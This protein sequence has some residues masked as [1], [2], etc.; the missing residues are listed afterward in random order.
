M[1]WFLP[2]LVQVLGLLFTTAG[3]HDV[4][5]GAVSDANYIFDC[6]KSL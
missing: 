5:D 3:N 4:V 6:V 1:D 2:G